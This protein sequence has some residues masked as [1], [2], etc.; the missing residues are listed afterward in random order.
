MKHTD[1]EGREVRDPVR[2]RLVILPD[3]GG[4]VLNSKAGYNIQ[5]AG[6]Y[7]MR[8]NREIAPA[9]LLGLASLS[10]HPDFIRFR[11]EIFV[12]GRLTT[13][14]ASSSLSAM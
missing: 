1:T 14:L 5:R 3:H 12:T 6:F 4:R 10:R 9:Q 13:R 11:G 7:V 2:V 8:N